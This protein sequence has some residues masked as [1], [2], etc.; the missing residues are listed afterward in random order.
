[1]VPPALTAIPK[2]AHTVPTVRPYQGWPLEVAVELDCATPSFL[3]ASL[4]FGPLKRQAFF[5]VAAE[6]RLG[7]PAEDLAQRLRDAAPSVCGAPGLSP[8]AQIARALVV[9]R[10]KGIIECLCGGSVPDGLTGTLARLKADLAGEPER[11]RELRRIFLSDDAIERKRAKVLGQMSGALTG[12]QI[13]AVLALIPVLLHPAIVSKL[14]DAADAVRLNHTVTY[15]QA[16]CTRATDEG[17]RYTMAQMRDN[18]LAQWVQGWANRFDVLPHPPLDL[19]E[20]GPDLIVLGS[21]LAMMDAAQRFSNC[22]AQKVNDVLMGRLLHVE[23]RPPAGTKGIAALGAIV[24]LRRVSSGWVVEGIYAPKNR[25][26]LPSV[27]AAILGK[28]RAAGVMA[29]AGAPGDQEQ[30]AA[31]AKW[32]HVYDWSDPDLYM[33][34]GPDEDEVVEGDGGEDEA[35]AA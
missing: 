9:L 14:K 22:L 27:K 30:L 31:T 35:E 26:A 16:H 8:L 4:Y 12:A 1:L 3:A 34:V 6:L 19:P 17:L 10:A 23:Y 20:G 5:S 7:A 13:E 21:G 24:E 33:L 32:L 2:S 15:L 28:L 18:S 29:Y 11:Y 25:R